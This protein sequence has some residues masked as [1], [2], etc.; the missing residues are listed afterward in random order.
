MTTTLKSFRDLSRKSEELGLRLI[1]EPGSIFWTENS[2]LQ[3]KYLRFVD[4][5][6]GNYHAVVVVDADDEYVDVRMMTSQI[7]K[8]GHQGIMYTPGLDVRLTGPS[9]ILTRSRFHLS[10]PAGALRQ[11]RYVGNIGPESLMQ[12]WVTETLGEVAEILG[13]RTGK[14]SGPDR[15]TSQFG[16]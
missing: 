14:N 13:L 10:I 1:V 8:Y 7:G 11:A 15:P 5:G 6:E 4:C 2:E 12:I 3:N 9:I 16:W